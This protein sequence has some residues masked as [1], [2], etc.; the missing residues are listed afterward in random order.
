MKRIRGSDYLKKAGLK[1]LPD[2]DRISGDNIL[3][4]ISVDREA[5]TIQAQINGL[6]IT[7]VCREKCNPDVC[8]SIKGILIQSAIENC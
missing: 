1:V 6:H 4:I 2:R 7:A 8:E 5:N 3:H